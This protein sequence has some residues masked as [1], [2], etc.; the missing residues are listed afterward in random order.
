MH[1]SKGHHDLNSEPWPPSG[2]PALMASTD[3]WGGRLAFAVAYP[4]KCVARCTCVACCT[5]CVARCAVCVAR[6]AVCVT[7]LAVLCVCVTRCAVRVCV[8]RCTVCVT[9]WTM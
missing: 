4:A 5:V 8:T 6:C 2:L 7:R 9:R 1:L 3:V